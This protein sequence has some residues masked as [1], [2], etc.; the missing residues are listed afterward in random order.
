[1]I[2]NQDMQHWWMH[3]NKNLDSLKFEGIYFDTTKT[4]AHFGER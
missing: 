4:D 3:H 1:M 2:A